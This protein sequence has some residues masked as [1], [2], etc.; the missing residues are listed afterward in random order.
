MDNL[1]A[2]VVPSS[3]DGGAKIMI[4]AGQVRAAHRLLGWSVNQLAHRAIV[5]VFTVD[6]IEGLA[7][8]YPGLATIKTTLEAAGIEFTN[9]APGVRL[10]PKRRK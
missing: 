8:P 5:G 10:H 7:G 4:S 1:R 9:D 2:A 6:Q 3:A